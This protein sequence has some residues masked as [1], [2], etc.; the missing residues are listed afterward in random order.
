MLTGGTGAV[1]GAGGARGGFTGFTRPRPGSYWFL[2]K[3]FLPVGTQN[4]AIY[5]GE[6]AGSAQ[7]LCGHD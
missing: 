7:S 2:S 3:L 6:L 4:R 1:R 5:P